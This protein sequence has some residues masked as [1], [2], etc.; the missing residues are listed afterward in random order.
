MLA[1]DELCGAA[2][3]DMA[4][5]H[6]LLLQDEI[7]HPKAMA[8]T[9][10]KTADELNE[11]KQKAI[12]QQFYEHPRETRRRQQPFYRGLKKYRKHL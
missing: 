8:I 9:L 5:I 10:A 11:A 12:A 7:R 2:T 4:P 1:A 3:R 6:I